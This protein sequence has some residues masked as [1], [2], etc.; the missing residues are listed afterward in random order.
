MF[1]KLA[2]RVLIMVMEADDTIRETPQHINMCIDWVLRKV[3]QSLR[4]HMAFHIYVEVCAVMYDGEQVQ[5]AKRGELPPAPVDN[6]G[7]HYGL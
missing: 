2:A 4:A 7:Y 5:I 6:K 3:P 1:N